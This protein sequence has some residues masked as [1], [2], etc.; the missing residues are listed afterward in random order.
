MYDG[1]MMAGKP[2]GVNR[3]KGGRVG[4]VIMFDYDGVIV[5]SL[6]GFCRAAA[7]AF[8]A[9]GLP[10]YATPEAVL[11]FHEQNWF[12]GLAAAG[13]EDATIQ[14]IEDSIAR[15]LDGSNELLPF[16]G[17]AEAIAA[18]A[19]DNTVVIITSSRTRVVES[20][21]AANGIEGVTRV[22]GSDCETSKVTKI[23]L[24]K[25]EYGPGMEYWYIGDT[26]GDIVEGKAA[27]VGTIAAA[28]GWHESQRLLEAQPDALADSPYDLLELLLCPKA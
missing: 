26:V 10:Q 3:E 22:L 25:A 8:L 6:E 28:W 14:G 12:A 13:I 24:V 9:A 18:L 20:F 16:P 2:S 21:L 15:A 4:K 1:D 5:D 23:G 27:H 17:V 11:E 7:K 19:A